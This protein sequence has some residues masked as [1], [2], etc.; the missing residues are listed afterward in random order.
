[1]ILLALTLKLDRNPTVPRCPPGIE[2]SSYVKQNCWTNKS[3]FAVIFFVYSAIVQFVESINWILL[4]WFTLP[5]IILFLLKDSFVNS[6]NSY[7]VKLTNLDLLKKKPIF[8]IDQKFLFSRIDQI[9]AYR[10]IDFAELNDTFIN[11]CNSTCY[12]CLQIL[13]LIQNVQAGIEL[14]TFNFICFSYLKYR[15]QHSLIKKKR[16]L[17]VYSIRNKNFN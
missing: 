10:L 7:L 2:I 9:N 16:P 1:M 3:F 15:E 11:T 6:T 17:A 13:F 5:T 8:M 4:N 12:D 14:E